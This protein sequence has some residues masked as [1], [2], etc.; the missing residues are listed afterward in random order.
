MTLAAG[1]VQEVRKLLD[2][3]SENCKSVGGSRPEE[4]ITSS[5]TIEQKR[6]TKLHSSCNT[7]NFMSK[8][9]KVYCSR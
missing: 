4:E 8:T 6:N 5:L 7:F 3:I 9:L 1:G 2:V